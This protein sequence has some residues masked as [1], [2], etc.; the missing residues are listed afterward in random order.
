MHSIWVNKKEHFFVYADVCTDVKAVPHDNK[1]PK[2]IMT[3]N[4]V[5]TVYLKGSTDLSLE[6]LPSYDSY[7]FLK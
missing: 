7:L 6:W 2:I 3:E 5:K 4:C 1:T